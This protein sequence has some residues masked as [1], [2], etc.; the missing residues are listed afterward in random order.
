M[1]SSNTT[2]SSTSATVVVRDPKPVAS[3]S[4]ASAM[5]EADSTVRKTV[6]RFNA[7]LQINDRVP[8]RLQC[9]V[10]RIAAAYGPN[11]W[12]PATSAAT[13]AAAPCAR[14]SD[15]VED[16]AFP[17]LSVG[18]IVGLLQV[19][20]DGCR[21]ADR[22]RVGARTSVMMLSWKLATEALSARSTRTFRQPQTTD[23]P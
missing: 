7:S 10:A 20:D 11:G 3:A 1:P 5:I 16:P 15:L 2:G 8:S 21:H 6:A 12:S 14:S 4:S 19:A 13:G 22:V 23:P 9:S 17:L 18:S